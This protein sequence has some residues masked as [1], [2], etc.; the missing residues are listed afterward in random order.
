MALIE[1]TNELDKI[2]IVGDYKHVQIR[3]ATWVEKD[4]VMI[5][6]KQYARRVIAPTDNISGESAEVKALC[7]AVHTQDIKDAYTAFLVAQAAEM[8]P[9]E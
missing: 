9:A 5:G 6:G 1:V 7:A 4:G 3:S 8:T 2:E